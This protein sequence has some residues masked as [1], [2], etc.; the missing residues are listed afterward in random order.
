MYC[1][2][3]G[4]EIEK[5]VSFCPKCGTKVVASQ[6]SQPTATA[7][8]EYKGL[9]GW[10]IVLVLGML[11]TVYTAATTVY[12]DF[13]LFNQ[14]TYAALNDP[15]SQLYVSNFDLALKIE[16]IAYLVLVLGLAY[17][18]YLFFKQKREFPTYYVYFLVA[19]IA[20]SIFENLMPS[21]FTTFTSEEMRTSVLSEFSDAPVNLARSVIAAL[22]WIPYMKKSERVKATFIN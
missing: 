3:C 12:T 17:T 2:K 19:L 1:S 9:G 20:I 22:I 4:S 21:L 7:K 15:T 13:V 6:H 8:E 11:Y 5:G 18:L 10:L 14:P 16:F